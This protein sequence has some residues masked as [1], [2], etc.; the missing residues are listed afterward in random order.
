MDEQE[1]QAIL[2]KLRN[3]I[4]L[5]DKELAL[6]SK[7]ANSSAQALSAM[8]TTLTALGKGVVSVTKQM[9]A[10]ARGASTYNDAITGATDAVG[11]F[12]NQ[13]GVLGKVV[14]FVVKAFG[15]YASEVNRL[16]DRLYDS[17]SKL[18]KSGVTASDGMSG[19]ADAARRLGFGLSETG[20]E[21]FTRLMT[22]AS[23]DLALMAGS[24]MTGRKRFVEIAGALSDRGPVQQ[25]FM[26]LGYQIEDLNAM[27][28]NYI[29]M[30]V[31][32]GRGRLKS[33]R[34]LSQ[35]TQEYIKLLD[36]QAKLTG[37]SVDSLQEQMDAQLRNERFQA[38]LLQLEAEGRHEEAQNLRLNMAA[39]QRVAPEVAEG[40]MDISAGFADT[41]RAQGV[42]LSGMQHIPE[43][44]QKRLGGGFQELGAAAKNTTNGF[45]TTL[46]AVGRFGEIF[47]SLSE[48][49]RLGNMSFIDF[50]AELQRAITEQKKQEAGADGLVN[51]QTSMRISQMNARDSLQDLI[52]AGVQPLTAA[53]ARLAGI[54]ETAASVLNKGKSV[55]G[56]A[57]AGATAGAVAGSVIPGVGTVAGGLAGGVAGAITGLFGG[58][59]TPAA[60]TINP[61][62]VLKFTGGTGSRDHFDKLQPH[63][64][65]AALAMAKDYV[66]A[67]G[68]RLQVNSAFR[69]IEEQ[70][71]LNSGGNPKAAP[72]NSL[73]NMGRA[74]DFNSDQVRALE[75]LGL[76]GKH[77]FKTLANDP[78]HVYMRNGGIA[79]GPESGY[80][81]TLHGTE[82][83]VPL[84]GGRSIPVKMENPGQIFDNYQPESMSSVTSAIN[85]L[86]DEIRNSLGASAQNGSAQM[87]NLLTQIVGLQRNSNNTA[88]RILQVTNN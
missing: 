32:M 69:S 75:G 50:E 17:Y 23:G 76:L 54:T 64:R 82:A 10:G 58:G 84:S 9:A 53:M 37:Q 43:E 60:G 5:T 65:A 34:E 80:A 66:M 13:F 3:G 79:S 68:Q 39:L 11:N 46:G 86:R 78:P 18:G 15:A 33:D 83:V 38:K 88:E 56:G 8:N 73:H 6:L 47:N 2:E 31:A 59:G 74:L 81:A 12:A 1:L 70:A 40:L 51:T 61:D 26:N 35:S 67:T 87:I 36:L 24:A 27:T 16:G 30:E 4:E 7:N 62:D 19:L 28:A 71:N 63:V 22:R 85:G 20:I 48:Q 45:G 21:E 77:G 29:G 44:M 52:L 42:F 41:K 55:L 57:A 49:V 25:A 14:G 72:G